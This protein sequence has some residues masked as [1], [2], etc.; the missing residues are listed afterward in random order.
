MNVINGGR[1]ADNTVDFQEFMIAPHHAPNFAEAIR[2]GMETFHALKEVLRSK[3]Y[4]TGVGDEGGFAP[5]L[6]SNE[7]A[8]RFI[9]EAITKPATSPAR[10]F[11]SVS[12]RPPARCGTTANICFSSPTSREVQKSLGNGRPLE[13]MDSPVSHRASGRWHG[14]T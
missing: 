13:V 4:S 1:H 10:T 12:I 6:K 9:L 11:R 3:G 8:V 5:D 7:E 2:M 14:R